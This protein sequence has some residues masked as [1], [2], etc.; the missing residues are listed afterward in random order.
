MA[1]GAGWLRRLIRYCWRYPRNVVL[2]LSGTLVVTAV[3]A[4]IPLIQRQIVD[5]LV[6]HGH[7]AVWPL[8][9]ALFGAA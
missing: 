4:G 8:A 9:V 3:A 2:A 1:A 6:G 5:D 7:Q